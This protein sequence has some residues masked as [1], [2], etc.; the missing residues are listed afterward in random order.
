S[1][2]PNGKLNFYGNGRANY[3]VLD[4]NNELERHNEGWMAGY[5]LGARWTAW[6]GGAVSANV[7]G[8]SPWIQLQ[9]K[10]S[11]Y[12]YTSVGVTQKLLKDKF[13]LSVYISDPFAQKIY[14]KNDIDDPTYT[15]HSESFR[16]GQT[17]RISV[18]YRFGKMDTSVKKARRGISNDDQ[19]DSGNR[20]DATQN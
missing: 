15:M 12:N 17:A 9:G 20:G 6:K 5:S 11:A 14:Y 8:S 3:V 13:D 4:S 1:F 7:G 2:R 19:R 16:W 18:I 10:G